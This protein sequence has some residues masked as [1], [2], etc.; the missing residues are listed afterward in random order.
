M[1]LLIERSR[2]AG[3]LLNGLQGVNSGAVA[4]YIEL[5]DG[6]RPAH[7]GATATGAVLSTCTLSDETIEPF[8]SASS[9]PP[10]KAVGA[11][12]AGVFA[13]DPDIGASGTPT[14]FRMYNYA[15]TEWIDGDVGGTGS[16]ADLILDSTSL[17]IHG[18]VTIIQFDVTLTGVTA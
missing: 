10:I 18:T 17:I 14:W 4:G 16:G 7:P 12:T 15:G 2:A 3:M 13:S 1:G 5:R 6:T 11:L 8:P 9:T